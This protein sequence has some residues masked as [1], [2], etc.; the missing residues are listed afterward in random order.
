MG[1]ID[2]HINPQITSNVH[3]GV[4]VSVLHSPFDGIELEK[5]LDRI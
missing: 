3:G 5:Q 4:P 1:L 2:C